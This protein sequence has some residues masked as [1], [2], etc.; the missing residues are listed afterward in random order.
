MPEDFLACVRDG[1]RVRTKSLP[2]G[3]FMRICFDK[4]GKSH[5]G[6]IMTKKE[7][8][9][10]LI[11]DISE[12]TFEPPEAGNLPPEGKDILSHAYSTCRRQQV[13]SGHT[14]KEK[15]AKTA[16]GAVHS[17][18]W[19]KDSTGNWHKGEMKTK[20]GL[21]TK[22]LSICSGLLESVIDEKKMTVLAGVLQ[23]DSLSSNG[24]FYPSHI[25]RK[26]GETLAGKRS[27]IG[28]DTDNVEDVVAKIAS[29]HSKNGILFAEFKFGSDDKSQRVFSKIKEGLV[30]STSIRASGTTKRAKINDEMVDVVEELNIHT[31]DWVLEGGVAAAKVAKVFESKPEI[32]YR[33]NREEN[34]VEDTEKLEYEAKIKKLEEE[35]AESEKKVKDAEL[36][37]H[38]EKRLQEIKDDEYKAI[39]KESISK[40][41]TQE[42]VDASF[43]KLVEAL[44][45]IAKKQ[46]NQEIIMKPVETG[47]NNNFQTLNDVLESELV[48]REDKKKILRKAMGF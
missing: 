15:C 6:E 14:D 19:F 33:F 12:L 34:K 24:R 48:E 21:M 30:D 40:L 4:S 3:K 28:H 17:A 23:E 9:D 41:S 37:A 8:D 29:A 43:T 35:K 1:G 13:S 45:K 44:S 46:R 36:S 18:G 16:W 2:D 20:G 5:A 42:E 22:D 38:V 7:S 39:V 11:D 25:V 32:N 31:V 47:S 26:A 27:L 10:E